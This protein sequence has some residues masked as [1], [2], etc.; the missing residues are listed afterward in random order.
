MHPNFHLLRRLN[1][2]FRYVLYTVRA[3]SVRLASHSCLL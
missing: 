2:R 1:A 3:S